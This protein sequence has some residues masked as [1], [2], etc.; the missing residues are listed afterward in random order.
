LDTSYE[1]DRTIGAA[2]VEFFRGGRRVQLELGARVDAP[3]G[4][5]GELSPR[6]G[7]GFPLDRERTRLRLALGRAFKLPS[8]FALAQPLVGNPA[9]EPEI[10]LGGDLG[11]EREFP[12]AA[13]RVQ[14]AF[15]G[16]DY[17][18][19][20]DFVADPFP[21]LVNRSEVR[22]RGG[23]LSCSW[24]PGARFALRADATFQ[25]VEDRDTGET[26]VHRPRWI[27][28]LRLDWRF[29]PRVSWA[30]DG[31]GVAESVDLQIALPE[32][33]R[34]PGYVIFGTT[35]RAELARAWRLDLRVDNLLD[36]EYETLIGFPGP[37][38]GLRLVVRHT[39]QEGVRA[40]STMAGE[41][42]GQP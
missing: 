30:L 12:A 2:L 22:T 31:Q 8:F 28:G 15:F 41:L 35:L 4:F 9:L 10:A 13:L 7:L 25:E 24:H 40:R 32:R 3:E 17:R 6:L 11:L 36:K 23:E 37:E 42:R 27:G 21:R 5:G 1:I 16:Y 34:V 26:L 18:D 29:A 33:D 14:L 38:R 39:V 20:I 19:L